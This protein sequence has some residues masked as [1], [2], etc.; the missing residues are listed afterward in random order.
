VI[1]RNKKNSTG[2]QTF[3]SLII[4]S[5][6]V[7]IVAGI[8]VVQFRY[9]PAVLKNDVLLPAAN[10]DQKAAPL[11]VNESFI[12]LPQD[13]VPLTTPETFEAQNLSDKIDGKAELYL[14]AGFSRLT[15]QRFKH[16]GGSDLWIEAYV[17]D[18]GNGQNA[19]SVFSAQRREDAEA[20]D[21]G[22]YSYRTPNA[23]FLVQGQYYIEIIAS[24]ASDLGLQ[25]VKTLA[26]TFIANNPTESTTIDEMKLFPPEHLVVDSISLISTDAFGYE[27]LDKVY[28]AEYKSDEGSLMAYLSRRQTIEEA[29][30]LASAYRDFLMAFGGQNLDTT[31]PIK[32]SKMVEILETYEIIF[33]FGPFLAGVREAVDEEQA[34]NLAIQLYHKLK[35]V[36]PES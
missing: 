7:I 13:L 4:L 14:S 2:H 26:R 22:Q 8:T 9:N 25:P 6:L 35:G 21:F 15:S 12:P 1:R 19:F 18:M 33:S 24:E 31:L 29:G 20:L 11:S 23:L 16:K 30:K 10:K 36:T 17:Y 5:T 34:K 27:G 32:N 28:T 3:V